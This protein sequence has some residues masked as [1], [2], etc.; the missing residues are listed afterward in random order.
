MNSLSNSDFRLNHE[1]FVLDAYLEKELDVPQRRTGAKKFIDDILRTLKMEPMGGLQFHEALDD[2]APGWS[3][4]QPI[5]TSHISCHYFE[6][7]G[8]KPHVRIDFYSCRSVNW[9]DVIA[10]CDKHFALEKWHG[11]FINRQIGEE[12]NR[13]IIDIRGRGKT[14]MSEETLLKGKDVI[15]EEAK[16]EHLETVLASM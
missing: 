11:T 3:F 16:E 13:S 12:E 14:I 9:A 4:I 10:V 8:R 15:V 7:P 5:T 2:R 6:R 1:I